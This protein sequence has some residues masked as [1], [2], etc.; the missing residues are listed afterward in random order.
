MSRVSSIKYEYLITVA[1]PLRI[2]KSASPK[3]AVWAKVAM[4]NCH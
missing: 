2:W 4:H 3:R 1:E